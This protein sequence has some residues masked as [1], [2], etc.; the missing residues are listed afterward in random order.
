MLF[1]S[2]KDLT[3]LAQDAALLQ[4][5]G[6]VHIN[7]FNSLLYTLLPSLHHLSRSHILLDNHFVAHE[8]I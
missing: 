7:C 5:K 6:Q 2:A 1:P 8:F 3:R 4:W